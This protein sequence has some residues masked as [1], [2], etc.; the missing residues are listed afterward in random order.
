ML[1]VLSRCVVFVSVLSGLVLPAH[2]ALVLDPT[3]PTTLF[4]GINE[5]VF[6][7]TDGGVSWTASS[8][9]MGDSA[10]LSL[11]LDPT[12]PTTIYGVAGDR[13]IFKSVD[14]GA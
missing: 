2:G 7:S 11:V 13:G 4:A 1:S 9:G 12:T 6:K 3:T 10:V 8:T 14:G 5:G